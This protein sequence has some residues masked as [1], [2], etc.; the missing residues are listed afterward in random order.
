MLKNKRAQLGETMT[1]VIA[2]IIVVVTLIVFIYVSSLLKGIRD[3]KI[4]DLK[5]DSNSD[6]NWIQSKISFAHSLDEDKNKE[7]IDNWIK[8]A[9]DG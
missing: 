9:E 5:L 4:P 2:T 6:V 1:W 8:E 7:F 3:V